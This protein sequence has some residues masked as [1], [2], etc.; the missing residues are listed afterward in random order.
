MK[1]VYPICLLLLHTLIAQ[2]TDIEGTI[3]APTGAHPN[4]AVE[5]KVRVDGNRYLGFVKRD[6]TFVI[7][8]VAPGSYLVEFTNPVYLFQVTANSF[9]FPDSLIGKL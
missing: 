4:W 3:V 6:G 8:D 7:S 1:L 9:N 2:S 5:T